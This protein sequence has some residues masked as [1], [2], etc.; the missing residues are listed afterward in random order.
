[1][2]L[3]ALVCAGT[4]YIAFARAGAPLLARLRATATPTTL[5]NPTAHACQVAASTLAPAAPP[6]VRSAPTPAYLSGLT[7]T[8][9]PDLWSL[10]QAAASSYD[11]HNGT[12]SVVTMSTS[13]E[14]LAEVAQGTAQL[15]GSDLTAAMV[16]ANLPQRDQLVE[17]PFAVM[18]YTLVASRAVSE[19]GGSSVTNLTH[20]QLA[21]ILQGR[22]TN[23]HQLGGIDASIHF[24]DLEQPEGASATLRR[25]V[26]GG[27][28]ISMHPATAASPADLIAQV[29][30]QPG[31]LGYVPLSAL[32]ASG[33]AELVAPL[34]LDGVAATPSHIV[35]GT[36]PFWAYGYI[37]TRNDAEY[38]VQSL[39]DTLF[40]TA[41]Q[42]QTLSAA[43]F[44]PVAA[45][46]QDA[47]QQHR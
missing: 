1:M 24:I 34:C 26:P 29:A 17:R 27:A 8:A 9:T 32:A 36:Y 12:A 40:S 15:G 23:W 33:A 10:L 2:L 47:V 22:I 42:S 41:F 21:A 38:A 6:L 44:I 31:G 39:M 35:D 18:P 25:D 43:G 46:S 28:T 45:L 11:S 3:V 37:V 7:L 14:A 16:G 5:I 4:G 30:A 13:A 20:A 19:G